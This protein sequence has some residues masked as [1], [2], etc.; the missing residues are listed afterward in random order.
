MLIGRG[1]VFVCVGLLW[2]RIEL[3]GRE[4]KNIYMDGWESARGF[5]GGNR[6][7]L[8]SCRNGGKN[9]LLMYD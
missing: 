9:G 3:F 2:S 6:S 5:Y 7:E 8:C 1:R 4:S